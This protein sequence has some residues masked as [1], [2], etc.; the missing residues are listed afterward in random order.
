MAVAKAVAFAAECGTARAQLDSRRRLVMSRCLVGLLGS[1]VA[2]TIASAP[3]CLAN[4][5]RGAPRPHSARLLSSLKL[6]AT[7]RAPPETFTRSQ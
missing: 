1:E 4:A 6:R 3:A 2:D 5:A 7:R